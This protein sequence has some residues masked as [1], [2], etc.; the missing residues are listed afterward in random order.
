MLKL[1]N[2]RYATLFIRMH[3]KAARF[4]RHNNIPRN[5][6]GKANTGIPEYSFG[7]THGNSIQPLG[8]RR[9]PRTPCPKTLPQNYF[10]EHSL[11]AGMAKGE[12]KHRPIYINIYTEQLESGCPERNRC[13]DDPDLNIKSRYINHVG[14][15]VFRST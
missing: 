3:I 9:K 15:L 1:K 7:H 6:S 8:P 4:T 14:T 11:V 12:H 13:S 2:T 5:Q 10:E